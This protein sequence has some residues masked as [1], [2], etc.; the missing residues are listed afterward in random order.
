MT[1]SEWQ[2]CTDPRV[3]L[4]VLPGRA[5]DRKL[6]L[7]ACSCC[8]LFWRKL[9]DARCR[10][11]VEI[12][13][14]FA[15]GLV[16]A[17]ARGRAFTAARQ[18]TRHVGA[19]TQNAF[20]AAAY[21]AHADPVT[22][23][24]GVSG[25]AQYA[26]GHWSAGPNGPVLRRWGG[27]P[28]CSLLRDIF[29]NPFRPQPRVAPSCLAWDGGTVKN[30]AQSIYEGRSLPAGTLDNSRLAVLADALEDAGC[31]Q[32]D[33]LAHLRSPGPHVRGCWAVDLLLGKG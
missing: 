6:R 32:P 20:H 17:R 25:N 15:D 10:S 14:Q 8:R 4:D 29:G 33:L 11:A 24:R 28:L 21:A 5:S 13:E 12:A 9:T 31:E 23:A 3:M 22:A 2:S 27:G 1:E 19:P 16:T 7:F 30:L 18:T 26:R